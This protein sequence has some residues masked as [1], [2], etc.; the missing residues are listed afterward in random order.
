MI[1]AIETRYN[2]YRFRSRL[3]ARWA[4]FFDTLGIEYLYEDQG[5]SIYSDDGS[6]INYLPDFYF[7]EL[8]MFGEVKGC[9]YRGQIPKDD[10]I[11]MSWMLE[12][13]DVFKNGIIL[14][15]NIPNPAN[16]MIWAI[17]QKSETGIQYGF[18]MDDIPSDE[19]FDIYDSS[20][21]A[22]Q[23][24]TSND[25]IVVTRSM[26]LSDFEGNWEPNKVTKALISARQARFEYGEVGA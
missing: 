2:G 10:A 21:H 24:F 6:I 3:E 4:V 25:D 17:W 12:K 15:G 23:Y 13:N 5:Y 20:K 22:P 19:L 11:K 26:I 14:L 9:N 16:E 1:K 18:C 7:P 8:H